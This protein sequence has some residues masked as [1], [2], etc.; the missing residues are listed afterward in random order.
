MD[1]AAGDS[2]S[3]AR[4]RLS[5]EAWSA[6]AALLWRDTEISINEDDAEEDDSRRGHTV[7]G[8]GGEAA[9]QAQGT[10]PPNQRGSDRRTW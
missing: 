3:L 6:Q 8:L 7:T 10:R 1:I 5:S 2:H 9:G 4:A